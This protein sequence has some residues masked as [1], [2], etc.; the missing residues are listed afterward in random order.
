MSNSLD[1][2]AEARARWPRKPAD[3][4]AEVWG[5]F[6]AWERCREAEL[7]EALG[8]IE[9]FFKPPGRFS[10]KQKCR[11]LTLLRS[12]LPPSI[13][14]VNHLSEADVSTFFG[15]MVTPSVRRSDSDGDS[16]RSS[17]SEDRM[18]TM[19]SNLAKCLTRW[20][21]PTPTRSRHPR[22]RSPT[23]FLKNWGA[24]PRAKHHGLA[25]SPCLSPRDGA[26][27]GSMGASSP[28]S[29]LIWICLHQPR[30]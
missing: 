11:D 14:S 7:D 29:L 18:S 17:P 23:V 27:S 30:R 19:E 15:R 20:P 10:S 2:L 25:S 21:R 12:P 6:E 5:V 3:L 28:R 4:P 9:R 13:T 24:T 26:F 8:R 1:G 16:V 22:T